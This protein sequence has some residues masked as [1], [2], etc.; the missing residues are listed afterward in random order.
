MSKDSTIYNLTPNLNAERFELICSRVVVWPFWGKVQTQSGFFIFISQQK[1][2][3]LSSLHMFYQARL[4][5]KRNWYILSAVLYA[6]FILI[7]G[8]LAA[9]LGFIKS[10]WMCLLHWLYFN[11]NLIVFRNLC[12]IDQHQY[13]CFVR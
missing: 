3:L 12:S 10:N 13:N 11:K 2:W 8:N 1:G 7:P 6:H 9:Q 4:F 5:S